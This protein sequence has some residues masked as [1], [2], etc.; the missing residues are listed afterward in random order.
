MILG[1]FIGLSACA[2][3]SAPPVRVKGGDVDLMTV[4]GKWYGVYQGKESG[5][6][7]SIHFELVKGT[8]YAEGKVVMNADKPALATSL[9]INFVAIGAKKIKGTIG[10]YT[11]P[12]CKCKVVTEFIG[13]HRGNKMSGTFTTKV[14]GKPTTQTGTWNA[15]RK[16][17]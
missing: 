7:G 10:P 13:H 16:D 11:D 2:T 9:K 5:R 8:R 17:E 14:Q 3:T 12:T 6:K 1:L 4:A 15:V